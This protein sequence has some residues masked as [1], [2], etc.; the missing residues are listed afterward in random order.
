[1]SFSE[2][3][4]ISYDCCVVDAHYDLLLDVFRARA[5]GER[6]VISRYY[7][8]DL[9]TAGINVLI[10][11]L[12]VPDEYIPEMALRTAMA[13][14]GC[15]HAEMRETP[16]LFSLCRTADEAAAAV[17]R[18]EVALFLS[19]EGIDPL[20]RDI[21][22]LSVFYELGVRFV[23]L[24]W[25]RRNFAADGCHFKPIAEG[26]VGGLTSFGVSLMKEIE[27]LGM[28]VDTAHLNDE[29]FDDVMRFF[30]GTVISSHTNC[31]SLCPAAR[32]LTDDQIRRIAERG[33]VIGLNNMIHFVYANGASDVRDGKRW[34]GLLDHAKRIIEIAG[35]DHVGL[36][37]DLCEFDKPE[38]MRM[39]SIFPSYRHV[40]PFI[41]A[42]RSEFGEEV[43]SKLL[44]G[45]WMRVIRKV[46]R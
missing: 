8:D 32:N 13:Q 46:C 22:L 1:M 26:R 25:S 39:K 23:G 20:G 2:H 36:G 33:G 18:G 3:N 45:N 4:V 42:V 9:R 44:G 35:P 5:H 28:A 16:G 11:S 40:V 17:R 21:N 37:L 19:F 6:E 41:D 29:G 27:R 31:R 7:L 15:L 38:N 34:G 43:S 10:C 14:I 12:Y 30:G 24:V